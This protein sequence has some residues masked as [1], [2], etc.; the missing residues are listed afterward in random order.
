MNPIPI[1][2]RKPINAKAKL[3]RNM[4]AFFNV[5]RISLQVLHFHCQRFFGGQAALPR[6]AFLP[7]LSR[8]NKGSNMIKNDRLHQ[9]LSSEGLWDEAIHPR[10]QAFVHFGFHHV[11]GH[12]EDGDA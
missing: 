7:G 2:N 8:N 6:E 12:G 5:K 11:G 1:Q 9:L 4:N 3:V 10:F